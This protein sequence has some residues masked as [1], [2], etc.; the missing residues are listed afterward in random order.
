MS[1]PQWISR[2]VSQED[3]SFIY[4]FPYLNF[5]DH[6]VFCLPEALETTSGDFLWVM[7]RYLGTHDLEIHFL[8]W[9]PCR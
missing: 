4:V 3:I 6:Y 2:T 5:Y 1:C 7:N 8:V 9:L